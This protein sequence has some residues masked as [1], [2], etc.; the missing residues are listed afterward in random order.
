MWGTHTQRVKP[1]A[2]EV[3]RCNQRPSCQAACETPAAGSTLGPHVCTPTW[4][5]QAVH[6][7]READVCCVGEVVGQLLCGWVVAFHQLLWKLLHT[8][9]GR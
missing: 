7:R 2:A 9:T 6:F 1:E 8:Q 3:L 5:C 4:Q